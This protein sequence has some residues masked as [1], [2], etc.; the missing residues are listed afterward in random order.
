MNRLADSPIQH[1]SDTAFWIAH[2]RAIES[3][4]PDALFH[5]PLATRLTEG[6]GRAIGEA[7]NE[8]AMIGWVVALRTIIIDEYIQG[9]LA[10]GTD[11]VLNLGAGLDTRPYRLDL[12]PALRGIE[13]DFPAIIALK[14]ERLAGETPRCALR[15]VAVDLSVP[16]ARRALFADVAADARQVLVLSEGVVPYLTLADAGAL[17]EDLHAQPSFQS[18]ILDRF[19]RELMRHRARSGFA[20]QL[21][22]APFRFDPDDWE[23]F[24]AARGWAVREVRYLAVEGRQLGR[25]SPLAWWIRA[26]LALGPQSRRDVVDQMTGY[27]VLE[28]QETK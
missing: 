16:E 13:A 21:A 7:M 25:P 5:D 2:F 8:G 27:A 9:A 17:A 22:N 3:A 6:R 18:W 19:S 23:A 20:R 14:E 1:V 12:P 28:R 4:R 24:F 11:T 15:R 26:L 10:R